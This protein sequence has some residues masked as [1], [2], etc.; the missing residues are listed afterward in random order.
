MGL[1]T[2][3][4]AEVR[5][6]ACGTADAAE[7]EDYPSKLD[8]KGWR[9]VRLTVDANDPTLQPAAGF[10]SDSLLLCRECLAKVKG[11][12]GLKTPSDR[13]EDDLEALKRTV[14]R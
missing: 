13:S 4:L 5:C 10:V 7:G 11:L 12:L 3:T 14:R 1:T 2:R 8:R 6:D 9:R